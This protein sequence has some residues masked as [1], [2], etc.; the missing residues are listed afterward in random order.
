MQ[1]KTRLEKMAAIVS[2]KYHI[3]GVKKEFVEQML[4]DR[5]YLVLLLGVT[6]KYR[7]GKKI[8]TN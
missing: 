5:K 2:G 8:K 7:N 6:K 1:Q 4:L 3:T